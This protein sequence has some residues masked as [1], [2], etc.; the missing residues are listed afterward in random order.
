M[1]YHW[2]CCQGLRLPGEAAHAMREISPVSLAGVVPAHTAQLVFL[3]HVSKK[4]L[5]P[6]VRAFGD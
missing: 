1:W 5:R 6:F 4:Q 2:R 3:L